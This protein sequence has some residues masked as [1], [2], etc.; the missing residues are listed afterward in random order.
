M[1]ALFE[2]W[3]LIFFCFVF[4]AEAVLALSV[5]VLPQP[6]KPAVVPGVGSVSCVWCF[7]AYV[8]CVLAEACSDAPPHSAETRT[9]LRN[10]ELTDFLPSWLATSRT[11]ALPRAGFQGC[12]W[13]CSFSTG[14]RGPYVGSHACTASPPNQEVI[15]PACDFS[16]V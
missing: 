9:V 3:F 14:A 4:V 13:P 6:P 11:S 15:S 2:N 10:V 7:S 5:S 8:Q 16:L 1:C 12:L